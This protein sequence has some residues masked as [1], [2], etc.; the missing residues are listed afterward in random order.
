MKKLL[1]PEK[2]LFTREQIAEIKRDADSLGDMGLLE[3]TDLLA[4]KF[5]VKKKSMQRYATLARFPQDLYDAAMD[6]S[7][8]VEVAEL[9]A[10]SRLTP[11]VRDFL[12]REAIARKLG[13]ARMRKARDLVYK[14]RSVAEALAVAEG[15]IP[16]KSPARRSDRRTYEDVLREASA[17]SRQLG[18]KL[19][20][21]RELAP[22]SPIVDAAVS[23]DLFERLYELRHLVKTT[24]SET[25]AMVE[26]YVKM[27]KDH[28]SVSEARKEKRD[29]EGDREGGGEA[30]ADDRR[31]LQDLPDAEKGA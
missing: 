22:H 21:I 15:R 30:V 10:S 26:E 29:V 19:L 13:P 4:S 20:M 16:D 5:G 31:P 12:A 25:D 8:M 2:R 17:I 27:A 11:D 18:V 14:G 1:R 6:G 24:L 28:A 7:L 9:L 3:K 23:A